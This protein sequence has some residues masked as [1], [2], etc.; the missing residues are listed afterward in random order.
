MIPRPILGGALKQTQRFSKEI[1]GAIA[2]Y[3]GYDERSVEA[4]AVRR[5]KGLGQF[6]MYA[7]LITS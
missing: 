2:A 4:K 7:V 5:K 3:V 1:I 6:A